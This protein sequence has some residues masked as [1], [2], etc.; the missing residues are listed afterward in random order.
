MRKGKLEELKSYLEELKTIKVT[1]S[2]KVSSF[3]TVENYDYV[4]NNGRIISR[5]KIMKNG[6]DGSSAIIL[7]ITKE[8]NC[9]LVVQPRNNTK[10]G[11]SVEFPAGYI[12]KNEEAIECARRELEEETGYVP[13]RLELLSSFYQDQGC[14]SAYNYSYLA[15]NC[16]KV[17]DQNLDQDEIIKYFEC[18]FD[19]VIELEQLGYIKDIN[20]LYTLEKAK[21]YF[22]YYRRNKNDKNKC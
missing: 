22:K 15:L 21:Q 7:P 11:V 16:E 6:S 19:E 20:S 5:E 9:L 1:K 8:N 18:S 10:E 12:E 4:L 3:L 14:S 2:K 13:E 17:K